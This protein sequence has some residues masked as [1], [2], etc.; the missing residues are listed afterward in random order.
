[1]YHVRAQSVDERAIYIIIMIIMIII[2]IIVMMMM[3]MI[4]SCPTVLP[5]ARAS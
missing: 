1:M 5:R 4:I 2:I 3:M